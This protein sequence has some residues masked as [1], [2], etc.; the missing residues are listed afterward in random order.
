MHPIASDWLPA[1]TYVL[2][3]APRPAG[4]RKRKSS[5][6]RR[7]EKAAEQREAAQQAQRELERRTGNEGLFA[8]LDSLIGDTSQAQ[9]AKEASLG[10]HG[11]RGGGAAAG[12][13]SRQGH[14]FGGGA[15]AAG[16]ALGSKKPAAKVI[17]ALPVAGRVH[18][19]LSLLAGVG[20]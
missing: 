19:H 3:P 16:G 17:A 15:A 6:Q 14:L 7:R 11:G 13:T 5:K 4:K 20:T 18:V 10:L 12:G 9:A 8:V 2:Q 1:S